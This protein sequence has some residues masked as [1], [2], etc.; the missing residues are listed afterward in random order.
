MK[1]PSQDPNYKKEVPVKEALI[2]FATDKRVWVVA[3]V[4]FLGLILFV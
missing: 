3:A 4:V 1:L 2:E